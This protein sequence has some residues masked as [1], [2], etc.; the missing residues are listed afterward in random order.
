MCD[1]R[2]VFGVRISLFERPVKYMESSVISYRNFIHK[3]LVKIPRILLQ[4]RKKKKLTTCKNLMSH[5]TS[6]SSE[7]H[8]VGV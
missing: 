2:I 6:Q 1:S 4:V 3:R 5:L 8:T 7:A